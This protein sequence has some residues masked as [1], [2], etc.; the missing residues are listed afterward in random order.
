M[1]TDEF[2]YELVTRITVDFLFVDCLAPLRLQF[3]KQFSQHFLDPR[4]PVLILDDFETFGGSVDGFMKVLNLQEIYVYNGTGR[5]D[6]HQLI[7]I[8][9]LVIPDLSDPKYE[10]NQWFQQEMNYLG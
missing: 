5:T 6:R 2:L 3:M 1:T 7:V 4:C 9:N 10:I 8:P